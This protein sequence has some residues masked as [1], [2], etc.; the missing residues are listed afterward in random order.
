VYCFA[1][2]TIILFF[3][4]HQYSREDDVFDLISSGRWIL[5][6]GFLFRIRETGS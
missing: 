5:M 1:F 2:K 3:G 4:A 6:R